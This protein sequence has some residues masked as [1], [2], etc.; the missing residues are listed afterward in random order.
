MS[1]LSAATQ[2]LSRWFG[3]RETL[4]SGRHIESAD[5]VVGDV[6]KDRDGNDNCRDDDGVFCT[7]KSIYASCCP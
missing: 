3:I 6:G 4:R 7:D 1:D 2:L 5:C